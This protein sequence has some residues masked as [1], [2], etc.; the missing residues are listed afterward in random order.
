MNAI[1]FSRFGRAIV[2]AA[3]AALLSGQLLAADVTALRCEGIAG[4][5]GEQGATLVKFGPNANREGTIGSGV[6]KDRFGT[7]WSRAGT[8]VL[9]RY[10]LDGRQIESFKIPVGNK[11]NARESIAL[12]GDLLVMNLRDDVYTLNINATPDQSPKKLD[13]VKADE[14]SFSSADGWV[15]GVRDTDV[16]VFNPA[17]GESKNVVKIDPPTREVELLPDGR[18]AAIANQR[19]HIY[20]IADGTD[21]TPDGKGMAVPGDRIQFL[22]GYW[23]GGAWHGTLRRFNAAGDAD[24][25]VVLGGGSGS[26]IGHLESNVEVN[27]PRGLAALRDGLVAISGAG[28]VVQFA[29]WEPAQTRFELVRRIGSVPQANGIGLGRDGT[30]WWLGGSWRWDDRC[31]QP[32]RATVESDANGG[33]GPVAMLDEQIMAAPM[34]RQ[35]KPAIAHGSVNGE[36]DMDAIDAAANQ[37]PKKI[38]GFAVS[39]TKKGIVGLVIDDH[40]TGCALRLG[41]DGQPGGGL[42]PIALKAASPIGTLTSLASSGSHLWASIDGAVVD[43]A[44]NGDGWEEKTRWSNWGS[45]E[46]EHF[47]NSITLAADGDRL[48]VSDSARQRVLLFNSGGDKPALVA[49]FGEADHAGDDLAH[50]SNPTTIAAAGERC[51]V[52]DSANQRLVKLSLAPSAVA[53]GSPGRP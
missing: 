35:N 18:V 36:V 10:T 6:V 23:Y 25:G 28:G 50:L 5:S 2:A 11:G 30:I 46:A 4:N 44:P 13:G 8:G 1:H 26:F 29:A 48:W 31:D 37:W 51:V 3:V 42:G 22:G 53:A 45:G 47:G 27:V 12:A 39:K 7:L 15:A 14:I 41:R 19:L 20:R 40:G 9:N 17:T 38:A 52:F 34:V 49:S 32:L 21:V 43:F 33:A 24:P 16:F